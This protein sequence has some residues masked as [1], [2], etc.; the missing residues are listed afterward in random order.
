M[1]RRY[2]VAAV[3]TRPV[4]WN[5]AHNA[6]K[7][8]AF[9]RGAARQKPDL[10]VS[11]EGMLEGYLVAD[12]TWHRERVEAL[13]DIAEPITGPHIT[14]FR[15]LA[16]L[17]KT[18]LCFGF[19]ERIGREAYNTAIFIDHHGSICGKYHKVS[20]TTHP[21]W[22][23]ARQGSCVRAFDTPLGRC[24]VLIC[25][26]RWFTILAR[27]LVLDG[28]QFIL[29]PTY[30]AVSKAQNQ[31]VLAR[32]RENGVPIVQAN[33]AGM[34]M[35]VSRGET[36]AYARGIDRITTGFIDIPVAP[37]P[38]AASVCE[39]EFLKLQPRMHKAY[40]RIA[41]KAIRK[42]SPPRDVQNSFVSEREFSRLQK[43]NWGKRLKPTTG[44]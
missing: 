25:S 4:R 27:S 5:K 20:E 44:K 6:D 19:A 32:A 10:I 21:A 7:M 26:D 28:A 1:F 17:L 35:I 31:A 33:A 22:N 13:L 8:E 42:Q 12:V 9:F 29:I 39:R 36:V 41:M 2:K 38:G 43:T 18:C 16:K 37:S 24:G 14:R 15:K 3:S 34:N 11:T 40:H 23:F 30:G